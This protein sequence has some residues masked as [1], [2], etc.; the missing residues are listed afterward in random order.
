MK[1]FISIPTPLCMYLMPSSK[2]SLRM[3]KCMLSLTSLE[4]TDLG[5]RDSDTDLGKRDF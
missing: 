5:K 2:I 3:L 1:L 4:I